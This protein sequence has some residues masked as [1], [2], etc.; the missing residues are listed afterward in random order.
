MSSPTIFSEKQLREFTATY[1]VDE[2]IDVVQFFLNLF[3]KKEEGFSDEIKAN[4][5]LSVEALQEKT[6]AFVKGAHI[7]SWN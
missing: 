2:R 5:K 7:S 1:S 4:T 3:K 6:A